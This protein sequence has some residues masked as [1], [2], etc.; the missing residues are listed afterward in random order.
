MGKRTP[1]TIRPKTNLTPT[2]MLVVQARA[3]IAGLSIAEF[4]RRAA[5]AGNGPPEALALSPA[6]SIGR[7]A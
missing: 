2:E 6:A 5:L 7:D 4:L 1:R 3:A